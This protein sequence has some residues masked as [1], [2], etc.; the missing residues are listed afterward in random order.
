VI[1]ADMS[2]PAMELRDSDFYAIAIVV[3]TILVSALCLAFLLHTGI[4]IAE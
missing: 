3:A 4:V 1:D 2:A